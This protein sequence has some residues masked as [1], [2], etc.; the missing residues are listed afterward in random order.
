MFKI[1]NIHEKLCASFTL[2]DTLYF[3]D[4]F[5]TN[6]LRYFSPEKNNDSKWLLS[7]VQIA[8]KMQHI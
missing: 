8:E 3:R 4:K 5:T 7:I 6:A 1:I 2:L